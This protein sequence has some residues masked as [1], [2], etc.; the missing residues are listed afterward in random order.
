LCPNCIAAGK[1][2]GTTTIPERSLPGG[3]ALALAV[4]PLFLWP[5]TLVSAPVA[6]GFVFVG[7]HNPGSLV[8]PGRGKLIVAGLIALLQIT[9]WTVFGIRWWLK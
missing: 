1:K 9:I 2:D 5:I 6:L 7:W 3:I 8:R 4:G